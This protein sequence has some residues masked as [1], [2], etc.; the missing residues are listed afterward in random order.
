LETTCT[1]HDSSSSDAVPK[2][3]EHKHKDEEYK[4]NNLRTKGRK[5]GR[6]TCHLGA[7]NKGT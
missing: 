2:T 3:A 6:Q 5:K 7:Q 4:P 1:W